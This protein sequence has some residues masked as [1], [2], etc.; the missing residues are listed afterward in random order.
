MKFKRGSKYQL[1]SDC[2]LY[3]VAKVIVNEQVQY[4]AWHTPGKRPPIALAARKD[5]SLD[6]IAECRRHA[7]RGAEKQTA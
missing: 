4:E 1:V 6:C 5:S 2:G 3:S 7:E